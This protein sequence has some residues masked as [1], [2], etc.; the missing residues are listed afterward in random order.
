MID[1]APWK[2]ELQRIAQQLGVYVGKSTLSR[3]SASR[4]ERLLMQGYYLLHKLIED[5]RIDDSLAEREIPVRH[6][7]SAGMRSYLADPESAG[8]AFDLSV[9]TPASIRLGVIANKIIHS[10]LILPLVNA[11][12]GL[13]EV[14]V[15][16]EFEHF[17]K[18]LA[19]PLESLL[20]PLTFGQQE[21][22]A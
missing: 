8:A 1:P 7:A 22:L 14:V 18:L 2:R 9:A 16:S 12:T 19:I 6:V 17:D 3:A 4:L 13:R 10:Y 21:N 11:E 15:C 20:A 5:H